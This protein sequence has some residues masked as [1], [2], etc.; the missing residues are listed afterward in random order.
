MS[1]QMRQWAASGRLCQLRGAHGSRACFGR[2]GLAWPP[3]SPG[4]LAS[5]G[6]AP[7]EPTQASRIT[8]GCISGLYAAPGRMMAATPLPG[9]RCAAALTNLRSPGKRLG[10]P[11]LTP[12]RPASRL[13]GLELGFITLT[14]PGVISD[15]KSDHTLAHRTRGSLVSLCDSAWLSA[16]RGRAAANHRAV[17]CFRAS[18]GAAEGLG[19]FGSG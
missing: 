6:L 1:M 11:V 2:C 16:G 19:L 18:Q 14:T 12:P 5:D 15:A 9:R 13:Q 7:F 4:A 17:R 3:G 10:P 8:E